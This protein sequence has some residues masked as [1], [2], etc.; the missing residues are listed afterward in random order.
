MKK[1]MADIHKMAEEKRAVVEVKRGEDILK[2]E[3]VGAKFRASG[4]IPKKF[5]NC[6]GF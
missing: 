6:F 2:V 1:K 3:E 5:F 4:T